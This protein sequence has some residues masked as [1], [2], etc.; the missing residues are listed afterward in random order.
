MRTPALLASSL[1]DAALLAA[2]ATARDRPVVQNG[3]P[4]PAGS[5]VA[6]GQPVTLPE[7]RLVATPMA[8]AQDSRCLLNARCIS[9]GRLVVT[10]RLDGIGWRET[11]PLTLGTPHRTHGAGVTLG[12]GESA[13]QAGIAA[14]PAAYRRLRKQ[15]LEAR[16][17]SG[18]RDP[19]PARPHLTAGARPRAGLDDGPAAVR[20]FGQ[21]ATFSTLAP[22]IAAMARSSVASK[23]SSLCWARSSSSKARLK[24]AIMPSFLASSAQASSRE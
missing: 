9:A 2:R 16:A 18:A 15:V 10:T 7:G 1:P 6:L 13:A 11:A 23:S 17:G 19:H 14:P 24:L 8:V 3:P 4:A 20:R 22:W 21:A 12:S 5:P